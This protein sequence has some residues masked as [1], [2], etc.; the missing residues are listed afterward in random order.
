MG[1]LIALA[2]IGFIV[3][4]GADVLAKKKKADLCN[5][6]ELQERSAKLRGRLK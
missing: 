4:V 6:D 2:V 3:I 5:K 1:L